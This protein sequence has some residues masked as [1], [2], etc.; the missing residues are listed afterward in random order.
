MKKFLIIFLILL[1][2]LTFAAVQAG[3]LADVQQAGVIRVGLPNEYIPF[4]FYDDAGNPSGID[5][6]L[7]QEIARRMGLQV[8]VINLA[9]DGMIDSLDLGQVDMVGGAFAVTDERKEK[10][11]FTRV[12]YSTDNLFR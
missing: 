2:S 8:K 11:D 12:Y 3:D 1:M 9:Y 10:I 6:A 7:I 5:T 4:V